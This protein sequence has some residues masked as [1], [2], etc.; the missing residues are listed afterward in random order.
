MRI[1]AVL[2]K[3]KTLS[4][5][6][7]PIMIRLT[8]GK[9]LKYKSVGVSLMESM[10]DHKNSRPKRK[11]PQSQSIEKL[12]ELHLSKYKK[13]WIDAQLHNQDISLSAIV[14]GSLKNE[15]QSVV[16]FIDSQV[17]QLREAKRLGNA[18]MYRSIKKILLR[19]GIDNKFG[20]S[21]IDFDFLSKLEA[22]LRAKDISESTLSIYFRTLKAIY[23]RAKK[24]SIVQGYK[25]PFEEFK[26]SKFKP[27]PNRRAIELSQIRTIV[28]LNENE[29]RIEED[30]ARD[31]FLFSYFGQG[32]NFVDLA[33][34]T[35]KSITGGR[36]HYIRSKTHKKLQFK[37]M[38]PALEILAKYKL[39][40]TVD[41]EQCYLFPIL[42]HRIHNTSEKIYNRIQK[43]RKEVNRAL[44]LVGKKAGIETP[45]T[46]Y[47]ARHT[48]ATVLKRSH[49]STPIISEM[50]G[51]KTESITQNYLKSFDN[52]VL[53]EALTNLL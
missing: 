30:F 19:Y 43:T 1:K 37:L 13:I 24:L 29:L 2:Y 41:L 9:K 3:S 49:V 34:L 10:W 50:M 20:F 16:C 15:S 12:I 17:Q 5:G 35:S 26:I 22:S 25:N 51:H 6:T 36:I 7:H 44:K 32:I 31:V 14:N 46:T 42:D 11:H 27:Q 45:L 47:V 4:D 39:D 40:E 18:K 21:D 8:H 28:E 38:E 53:D 48:F 23:N 52:D 33:G